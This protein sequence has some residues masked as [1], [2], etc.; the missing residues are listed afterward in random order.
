MGG[1][2]GVVQVSVHWHLLGGGAF[3]LI[4]QRLGGGTAAVMVVGVSGGR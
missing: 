3:R 4:E 2:G 1:Q